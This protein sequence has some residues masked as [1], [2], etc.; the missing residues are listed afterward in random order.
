MDTWHAGSLLSGPSPGPLFGPHAPQFCVL[1]S[2]RYGEP[3]RIPLSSGFQLVWPMGV[4]R[5]DW[6][7]EERNLEKSFPGSV[8][9]ESPWADCRPR[10]RLSSI[11]SAFSPGPL[12]ASLQTQ[13]GNTP[14]CLWHWG[15]YHS[16]LL[17]LNSIHTFVNN[18]TTKLSSPPQL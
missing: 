11:S 17:F 1:E 6:R 10:P 4:T 9:M 2:E 7:H 3:G 13:D 12:P 5:G 16:L 14:Q 15:L 18:P 8:H